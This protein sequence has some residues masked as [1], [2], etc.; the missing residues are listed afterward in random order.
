MDFFPSSCPDLI[1]FEV[2]D[3]AISSTVLYSLMSWREGSYQELVPAHWLAVVKDPIG[4]LY[5]PTGYLSL[6]F[7]SETYP[8]SFVSCLRARFA[9]YP[10]LCDKDF[11]K[12]SSC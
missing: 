5:W 10:E 2:R 1:R 9:A 6:K 3:I 4:S 7:L 11:S 12:Q 8:G